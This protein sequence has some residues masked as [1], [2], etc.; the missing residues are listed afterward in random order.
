MSRTSQP[1]L[2]FSCYT[3]IIILVCAYSGVA[4]RKTLY[5]KYLIKPEGAVIHVADVDR[6]ID[7][8]RDVLD[9]SLA[10]SDQDTE[11]ERSL[12][13]LGKKKL[14]LEPVPTRDGSG[15]QRP[16]AAAIL[17]RVR[18]GF[19]KLHQEL[20][21]RLGAPPQHIGHANYWES[22]QPGTISEI[23]QGQWGNQFAV[24]D[25]DGNMLVFYRPRRLLFEKTPAAPAR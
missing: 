12:S 13:L 8:Y 22:M 15:Y 4:A 7:F 2:V 21:A 14:F 1:V 10:E 25:P 16:S 11:G 6:A 20:I 23:F 19:E 5:D 3:A 18:N 9:F 17:I 24:C